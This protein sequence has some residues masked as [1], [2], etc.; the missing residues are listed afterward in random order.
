M[1][2]VL[3]KTTTKNKATKNKKLTK[4]SSKS[5]V[6]EEP[7]EYDVQCWY[8]MGTTE[9]IMKIFNTQVHV[10]FRPLTLKLAISS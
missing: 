4:Q 2:G 6:S 9:Q 7:D 5:N 8:G 3:Y 10:V 1:N